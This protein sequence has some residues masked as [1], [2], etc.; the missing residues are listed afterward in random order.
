MKR[1]VIAAL[2]VVALALLVSVQPWIYVFVRSLFVEDPPTVT[3]LLP[4]GFTGPFHLL[5]DAEHGQIVR[6]G[7]N[8]LT[9]RV[10]RDGTVMVDSLRE[11][12]AVRLHARYQSGYSIAT[13][14]DVRP[15]EVGIRPLGIWEQSGAT[16]MTFV[17]GTRHEAD[18]WRPRQWDVVNTRN[19]RRVV[20]ADR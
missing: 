9:I 10:P 1:L 4:D 3:L 7:G 12:R 5:S 13:N 14:A 19:G 17:V 6:L 15:D 8:G 20:A 16:A 11:L 18:R 2:C